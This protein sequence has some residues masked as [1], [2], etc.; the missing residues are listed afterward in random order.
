[1]NVMTA[2][3][4]DVPAEV[5]GPKMQ[6]LSEMRRRF[7]WAYLITG[8][9]GAEAA[10]MAGYSGD[11]AKVTACEFLQ[12]DDILQAMHETAWKSMRGLSLVATM[13][14]E[15]IVL[16]DGHPDQLKA[17]TAVLSR[18]GFAERTAVDVHH[19]GTVELSHTDAAVENLAYLQ[20]MQ[21]PE[22]M[23]IQQ[24]GHSGLARYRRMLEERDAKKGMKVIEHGKD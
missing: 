11:R 18:T 8:G 15:K 22:E 24:F 14:L 6:A 23:L 1:M 19:S 21:V 16:Q 10:R 3:P 12:R 20:S 9:Q 7:V 2:P 4:I 13:K 5:L 17:I